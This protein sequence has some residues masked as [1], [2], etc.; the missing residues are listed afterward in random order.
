MIDDSPA[1][2]EVTEAE[3]VALEEGLDAYTYV[4][5]SRARRH[6]PKPVNLGGNGNLTLIRQSTGETL[7]ARYRNKDGSYNTAELEKITRI[8]R[9]SLTGRTAGVAVKLAELLDAVEDHFGK[10]GLILLS[11]YRTPQLNGRVAGAARYSL[12]MLG[13]AADIRI[14]GHNSAKVARYARKLNV[15]GV[16]YYPSKGFT[17]LDVG[18]SRHWTAER[19]SRRPAARR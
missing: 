17:H 7:T 13:W 9:C 12:H 11:G 15:G 1:P 2:P 14:A 19:P 4:F 10:R 6:P 16:G 3:I 18:G 8:M 5:I